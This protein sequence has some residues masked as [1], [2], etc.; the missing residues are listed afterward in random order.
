MCDSMENIKIKLK[1]SGFATVNP[2]PS[3]TQDQ[4][5]VKK[6]EVTQDTKTEKAGE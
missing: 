5:I 6:E 3:L 2:L 1:A 4:E